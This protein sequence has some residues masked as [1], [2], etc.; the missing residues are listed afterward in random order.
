MFEKNLKRTTF[1]TWTLY[2]IQILGFTN[3]ALLEYSHACGPF[4][5]A[6]AELNSCNRHCGLQSLGHVLSGPWQKKFADPSRRMGGASGVKQS[7]EEEVGFWRDLCITA[8]TLT[9]FKDGIWGDGARWWWWVTRQRG[10]QYPDWEK[11][12]AAIFKGFGFIQYR[13]FKRL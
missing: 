11:D 3:K 2:N 13:A 8:V 12:L 4:Y 7:E 1:V 6:M 5:T 9:Y 10:V